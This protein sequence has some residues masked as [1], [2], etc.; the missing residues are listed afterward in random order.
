MYVCVANVDLYI[1][2]HILKQHNIRRMFDV[3]A[4]HLTQPTSL[5]NQVQKHMKYMQ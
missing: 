1:L 4:V 2:M 3:K 5:W